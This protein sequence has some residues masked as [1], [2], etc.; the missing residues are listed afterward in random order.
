MSQ[1]YDT[2]EVERDGERITVFNHVTVSG[3]HHVRPESIE[4]SY[5]V[6]KGD[7]VIMDSPDAI[8]PEVAEQMQELGV[9]AEIEVIDPEGDGVTVL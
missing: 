9:R 5:F 2:I 7:S 1:H 6:S 8:T 3:H 4:G